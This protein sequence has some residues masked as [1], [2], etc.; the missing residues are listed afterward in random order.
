MPI[1]SLTRDPLGGSVNQC[2]YFFALFFGQEQ[3]SVGDSP[4]LFCR[5]T[6]KEESKTAGSTTV[7]F[8]LVILSLNEEGLGLSQSDG[9][10]WGLG[11]YRKSQ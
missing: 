11:S 2:C 7:P 9:K 1:S 4:D 6:H 10:G 3:E 5:L 8:R